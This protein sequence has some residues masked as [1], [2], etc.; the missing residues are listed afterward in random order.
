MSVDAAFELM[1]TIAGQPISGIM[2]GGPNG[3]LG[4]GAKSVVASSRM[5][6][7]L[8]SAVPKPIT[9]QTGP[10]P[11][12]GMGMICG[13]KAFQRPTPEGVE[14]LHAVQD[15]YLDESITVA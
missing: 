3:A 9:A 5:N 12:G 14:L 6:K 7:A 15:V 11:A 2:S 10:I 4:V 1:T 13:R 8:P